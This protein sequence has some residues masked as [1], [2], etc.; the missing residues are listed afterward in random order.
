LAPEA[1]DWYVNLD[2]APS[3]DVTFSA[4]ATDGETASK[5]IPVDAW[6]GER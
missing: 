3:A 4:M 5:E 1:F 6:P 2:G